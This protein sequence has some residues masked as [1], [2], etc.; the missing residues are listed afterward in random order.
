MLAGLV[1]LVLATPPSVG[2]SDVSLPSG[3][4][5]GCPPEVSLPARWPDASAKSE[6]DVLA[7]INRY[8]E[9]GVTCRATRKRH[10]PVPPLEEDPG[11]TEAARRHS[12]YMAQHGAFDHTLGGCPFST[13]IDAAEGI[14]GT[15]SARTSPCAAVRASTARRSWWASGWP[16]A[17]ATA[18]R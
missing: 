5:R 3:R 4:R 15:P 1:A 10:R 14:G 11:L 9:E 2:P 18:R 6:E 13:W 8:R 17:A 16:A 12:A 7:V